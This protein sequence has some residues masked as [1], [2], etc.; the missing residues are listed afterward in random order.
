[1]DGLLMIPR[2]NFLFGLGS[3]FA[4]PAIV[5]IDGLMKLSVQPKQVIYIN[6]TIRTV[7][8]LERYRNDPIAFARLIKFE[9]EP[10]QVKQVATGWPN[11][12]N[13]YTKGTECHEQLVKYLTGLT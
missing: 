12:K 1:M 9:L 2:R 11:I 7:E 3:L 10:W 4:A 8:D 13:R 5:K 6:R